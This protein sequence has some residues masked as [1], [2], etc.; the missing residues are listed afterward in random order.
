MTK[1]INR[2]LSFTP[3]LQN[4]SNTGTPKSSFSK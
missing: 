2:Y 4:T 3:D 1:D